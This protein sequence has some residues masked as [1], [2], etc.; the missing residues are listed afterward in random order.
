M[1]RYGVGDKVKGYTASELAQYAR[2]EAEE[3]ER[4][5]CIGSREY[6]CMKAIIELADRMHVLDSVEPA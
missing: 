1:R 6:R 2:Q 5:Y 4:F 3:L